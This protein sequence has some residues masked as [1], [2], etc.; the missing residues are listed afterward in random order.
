M[1]FPI[2]LCQLGLSFSAYNGKPKQQDLKEE[3]FIFPH[4]TTNPEVGSPELGKLTLQSNHEPRP[5][6]LPMLLSCSCG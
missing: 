4:I 1:T 5:L 6:W 3:E 2:F